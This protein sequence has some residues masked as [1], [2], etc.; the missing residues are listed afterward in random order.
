MPDGRTI[1]LPRETIGMLLASAQAVYR[2]AHQRGQFG[3]TDSGLRHLWALSEAI[4]ATE[5]A[6]LESDDA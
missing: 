6:I 3:G 1:T 5:R 4:T 2:T